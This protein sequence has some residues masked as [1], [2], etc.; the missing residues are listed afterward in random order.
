MRRTLPPLNALRAFDAAG[1]LLSFSNAAHELNVTQG[2]ISRHIRELEKR[3]GAKLFVRLTRR[4]EL[5]ELGRAYLEE[6]RVALDRIERATQD[7]RGRREHR[8]LT[9][10]VLPSIASYWLMPRL[11]GFTRAHP[12]IETRILTSIQPVDLAA[13]EADLAI[14]VGPLP[15]RSYERRQPRIELKMVNDWRGVQADHLFPDILVPLCSPS[16]VSR[17]RPLRRPEDLHAYPL[18]HTATRQN[19]WAD[20]FRAQGMQPPPMSNASHYG[21]FFMCIQA[22][23][24]A[25]GVAIAP[26][27]LFCGKES[28]G[29]LF[30]FKPPVASAGDYHLL[31][32]EARRE[33]R[34]I[35]LF[36]S[37]LLEQAEQQNLDDPFFPTVT[38]S[39][40]RRSS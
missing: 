32:L 20:W 35:A 21:H 9:I 18:I 10:S 34:E 29:L 14:R 19:A 8:V 16:L 26:H 13:R 31:V 5:T 7:V 11:A 24:E 36:R 33:E 22:A 39:R 25:Q 15:G 27:I 38:G 1:R 28:E 23:R 2:A 12:K 4:I 3:L 17:Q 37:W 6:V 30:P 40:A